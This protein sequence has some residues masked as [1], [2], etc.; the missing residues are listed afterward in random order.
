MAYLDGVFTLSGIVEDGSVI[1]SSS[2]WSP[3]L[4]SVFSDPLPFIYN[5]HDVAI[6]MT[7]ATLMVFQDRNGFGFHLEFQPPARM[8]KAWVWMAFALNS[9]MTTSILWRIR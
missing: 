6:G 8:Y 4:V 1:C 9:T 2:A 3:I 5:Y 7:A